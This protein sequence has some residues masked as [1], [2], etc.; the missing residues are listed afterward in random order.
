MALRCE[1][2]RDRF[3]A[4]CEGELTPSE[5]A[6]VRRHLERCPGCQGEFTRFEKTLRMLHSVEEVEVPEG[7]LSG[8]YEKIE[9]RRERDF[10][11]EKTPREGYGLKW[12]IP[13]QAFAMVAIVFLAL[14]L[15]KMTSNEPAPMKATQRVETFLG[16]E[17][18]SGRD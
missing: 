15:T 9:G 16:R 6:E 18:G 12:K 17:K 3:S 8:V 14:Y 7:F 2:V 5:E 10:S 13:A 1:E 11:P 4:L